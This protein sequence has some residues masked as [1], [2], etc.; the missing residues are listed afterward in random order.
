ML[1]RYSIRS[2]DKHMAIVT[3]KHRKRPG[4]LLK[5]IRAAVQAGKRKKANWLVVEWLRSPEAKRLAGR[6]AYRA[7]PAHRTARLPPEISTA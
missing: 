7:M 6:W 1:P 4:K 5:R 2:P 3:Q